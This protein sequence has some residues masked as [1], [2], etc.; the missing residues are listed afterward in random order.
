MEHWC[1]TKTAT[2]SRLVC[3]CRNTP[4]GEPYPIP[5]DTWSQR[6]PTRMMAVYAAAGGLFKII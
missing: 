2:N 4:F 1:L 3:T 6:P 5:G